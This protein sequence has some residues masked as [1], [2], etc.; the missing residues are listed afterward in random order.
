LTA[1]HYQEKHIHSLCAALAAHKISRWFYAQL[2]L[3]IKSADGFKI[4]DF[5]SEA[6]YQGKEKKR[7]IVTDTPANKNYVFVKQRVTTVTRRMTI[8]R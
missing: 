4:F 8:K 6:L 1:S 7:K 2:K 5:N 3:R